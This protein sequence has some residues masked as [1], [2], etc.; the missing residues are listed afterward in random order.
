MVEES[1][2]QRWVRTDFSRGEAVGALVWLSVGAL[3][4]M[5]LEVMYLGARVQLP[6]G[7]ALALPVTIFFALGFNYVLTRTAMLWTKRPGIGLLP[8]GVW[9]AGFLVMAVIGPAMGDQW[10]VASAR[11][12]GLFFCGIVGGVWPLLRR[13]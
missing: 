6:N 7:T 13:Q 4:S 8:L 1:T 10:V 12:V 2:P 3:L 5:F 11:G 9:T